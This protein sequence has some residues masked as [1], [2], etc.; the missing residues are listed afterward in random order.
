MESRNWGSEQQNIRQ[1]I[2][3]CCTDES[4][5]EG[6]EK[7]FDQAKNK[8]EQ[9]Q[10][11]QKNLEE[12]LDQVKDENEQLQRKQKELDEIVYS[13]QEEA[14]KNTRWLPQQ[15]TDISDQLSSLRDDI[16]EWVG[17]CALKS[18]SYLESLKGEEQIELWSHV[19]KVAQLPD[20]MV[21]PSLLMSFGGNGPA[22]L[23]RALLAYHIYSQIFEDPF[24]FL[25]ADAHTHPIQQG[26]LPS[27]VLKNVYN[28]LVEGQ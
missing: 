18:T 2:T 11:K 22:L 3:E 8:N 19:S 15:D 7:S 21:D 10:R 1:P 28:E 27:R 20:K 14:R 6:L 5:I 17:M 25:N 16:E 24:Y 12:A 23:L 9:L 26:M 4:R 13:T